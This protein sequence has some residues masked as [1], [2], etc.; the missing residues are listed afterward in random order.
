MIRFD[1]IFYDC[2]HHWTET[3][4][5]LRLFS[6]KQLLATLICLFS[7]S[8]YGASVDPGDQETPVDDPI[9]LGERLALIDYL[10]EVKQEKLPANPTLKEL[11]R[12]YWRLENADEN[13]AAKLERDRIARLR[14]ELEHTYAIVIPADS[15]MEDLQQIKQAQ[16]IKKQK[17][18]EEFQRQQL[19]KQE[20]SN[21]EDALSGG[22]RASAPA[23]NADQITKSVVLVASKIGTGSGFFINH[24]GYLITNR[25]VVGADSKGSYATIYWDAGEK[26]KPENF[27]IVAIS[28]ERDLALLKPM[29]SG[30][31]YAYFNVSTS[32]QLATDILVAGY[33]LG[34]SI[35]QSLGTNDIDLT[36][37]KGS[38]SSV[39]KKGDQAH[40][41]QTDASTSQGNSGGPLIDR[42]SYKILGIITKAID[43]KDAGAHGHIMTFAIPSSEIRN[44]FRKHLP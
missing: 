43:P 32:Y 7:I 39:R 24:K 38:I 15:S 17:D 11:R 6:M 31:R 5:A 16:E 18:L 42:K 30:N 21:D 34:A 23:V 3:P 37:T 26:R 35:G 36:L 2:K 19:A 8:L 25:H 12:I 10:R 33:P 28:K 27:T 20:Q 4:F 41:L 29:K 13:K 1:G 9:G 44:Q 14:R 40:F 22:S